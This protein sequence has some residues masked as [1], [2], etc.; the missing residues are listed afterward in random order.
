MSV[1]HVIGIDPGLVHTGV[2]SMIFKSEQRV[3]EIRHELVDGPDAD[4]V[5][6]WVSDHF[7][8]RPKVYIE[9]YRPRQQLNA[10]QRMLALEHELR[11]ALPYATFLQNMGIKRVVVQPVMEVLDVWTF[12]TTSHHQDLRAAA[13]IALLGMV[14]DDSTNPVLASVMEAHIAHRPWMPHHL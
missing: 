11:R 8:P 10:D 1:A 12:H 7:D 3:V 14:K 6:L 9:R 4:A 2:V 5:R 13:R